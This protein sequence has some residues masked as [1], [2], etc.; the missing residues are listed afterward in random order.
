MKMNRNKS[1]NL[2]Q[3]P[4]KRL[5]RQKKPPNPKFKRLLKTNLKSKRYLKKLF[6]KHCLMSAK[7]L[8]KPQ[9][10][11]IMMLPRRL[12]SL[13]KKHSLFPKLP[14]ISK[15]QKKPQHKLFS[16]LNKLSPKNRLKKKQKNKL[17]N[18]N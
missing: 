4:P 11:S 8:W 2:S 12:K 3:L 18:K 9:S 17:P 13:R 6:R 15:P 5:K 1:W 16:E 7:F 10:P 14:L